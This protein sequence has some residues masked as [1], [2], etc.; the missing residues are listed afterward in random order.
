MK[1][2]ILSACII[3]ILLFSFSAPVFAQTYAF[4]IEK[5][6]INAYWQSDGSLTLAYEFFFINETYADPLDYVDV[7]LPTSNYSLSNISASVSGKQISH[8]AYSQYVDGIELGLGSNAIQP[9]S[10]GV[11]RVQ[12]AG[13]R[14]VLY[15]DSQDDGYASAV[16]SPTWFGSEFV[17]GLTDMTVIYHLPPGIEPNQPRYHRSPPGWPDE[18]SAG[19]DDQGRITYTWR[20]QYATGYTQYLFGASFPAS[21]VPEGSIAKPTIWQRLGIDPEALIGISIFCIVGAFIFGIPIMALVGEK[22]RRMKYLPPKI[23][24]EGHGIKRGLTAI[25]AAILLEQPMDKILT[26]ILFAVIK[27][28]AATVESN[29]P[30]TLTI[31]DPLPSSLR[32]YEIEFLEAMK[33]TSKN[34]RQK[35]LQTAMVSLV[36]GVTKKMK[37]FSRRETRNYYLEITKKAWEQVEKAGTPEVRSEKY[38]EVMEW[39]MLDKDYGDRTKDVFRHDPVYIPHWWHRYDPV[40]R[41]STTS[42]PHKSSSPASRPTPGGAGLPKLP[43]SDFA[44]SMVNSVQ[45]FAAGAIGSLSDFT[46]G[47]TKTTNPPPVPSSSSYSSG[48]G[49][50]G[51]SCACACACAGCACACAGGGR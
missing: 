34:K 35:A 38:D 24:I 39:T 3:L 40:Y 32:P 27:K 36:R 43:G 46:S 41:T 20:N 48:G 2:R 33:E 12:I 5:E 50:G 10:A 25:E 14:D 19:Y 15:I 6:T 51:S 9:G 1:R 23:A 29:N 21:F 37:G 31:P 11:V 49:G 7:G 45:D 26:M 44:A 16:F 17:T 18:P 30:L 13:I 47:V 42:A 8:I 4:S 22:R 28:E